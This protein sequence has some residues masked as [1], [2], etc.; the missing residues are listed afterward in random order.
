[1]VQRRQCSFQLRAFDSCAASDALSTTTRP[2]LSSRRSSPAG[3]TTG[4]PLIGAPKKTTDKAAAC[5]YS[6]YCGPNRLQHTQVSRVES[7]PA[8][9]PP[10]AGWQLPGSVQRVCPGVQVS[11]QSWRLDTCRYCQ[12][13]SSVPGRRQLRLARR[14]R[15][16]L[17]TCSSGYVR[18]W[19]FA[20]SISRSH[21][22]ELSIWQSQGQ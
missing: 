6:Q 2:L 10:L 13:V 11:T 9:R 19:A 14:G 3:S 17:S 22:L 12:P 20:Y 21:I 8:M 18:G 1:M 4:S 16:E 15:N 5:S 7:F